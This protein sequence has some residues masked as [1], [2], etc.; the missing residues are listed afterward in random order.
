[1][2][3]NLFPVGTS[4]Y[5]VVPTLLWLTAASRGRSRFPQHSNPGLAGS[6]GASPKVHKARTAL[7]AASVTVS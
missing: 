4:W 6:T 2:G 3:A 5:R 1:M 7:L